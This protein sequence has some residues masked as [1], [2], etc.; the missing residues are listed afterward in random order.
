MGSLTVYA[1][2]DRALERVFLTE[3]SGDVGNQWRS[4]QVK[5]NITGVFKVCMRCIYTI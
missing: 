3:I 4:M 2:L 1:E 5:L